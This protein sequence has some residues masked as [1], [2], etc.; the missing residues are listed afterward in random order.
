VTSTSGS[1]TPRRVA[2]RVTN[3]AVRQL[4]GGHP[5]VF[6]R[7]I[8]SVGHDGAPGDLAVVFDAKRRFVAVGLYDPL[9]PIRVRVLH[10]GAPRAID[11]A[12]WAERVAAAAARRDERVA[13]GDT[14]GY[15]LVHGEND[16]FPGLVVDRYDDT[17]VV[18]AYATAWL[19]HV[20]P[21][22]EALRSSCAPRRVV[23]RLGR[24][25]RATAPERDATPL[26]GALPAEPVAFL[27]RGLSF[28][29]DVV[30]GQKT[31]HFLDQRDNRVRVGR[32]ARGRR[33][34]DVFACTGG[35][36]V[37][38]AAGGASEVVSVDQ[39]RHA[40]DTARRNMARNAHR[41]AVAAC[42]HETIA[43]DA[44]DVME[45]MVARGERFDVVVVDPPSF[46]SRRDRVPAAL[47]A[48]ERLAGLALRLVEPGGTLVQASCSSRVTADQLE[49]AVQR[50]AQATRRRLTR[51]T[52]TGHGLDHPIGFPEGEYLKAIH[53]TVS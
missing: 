4:R 18:K 16:G 52:R 10:Q 34:L 17:L 27:E 31:G 43:G 51:V 42:R 25:A 53:A 20:P 45:G 24:V 39:S 5:W 32:L 29:A 9:S 2:V 14:T 28:E 30:R 19:A 6:D 21:V 35:F 1:A 8:T 37:H 36:S 41:P 3:D 48:Y 22:V 11:E 13:A 46:A 33:V 47:R 26:V 40:L 12:F 23:L 38:A 50:A 49:T 44:F 7:S 15:R